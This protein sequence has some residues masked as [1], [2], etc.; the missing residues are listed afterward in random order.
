VSVPGLKRRIRVAMPE[1]ADR[2]ALLRRAALDNG[3]AHART[4]LNWLATLQEQL[5]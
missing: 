1:P 4:E 3:I 5:V 2:R